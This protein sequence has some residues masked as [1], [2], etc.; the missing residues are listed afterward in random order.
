MNSDDDTPKGVGFPIRKSRDQRVLASSPGLSQRATSFI[1][2]RRQGIHQMP[3]SRSPR[4]S[5]NTKG[6]PQSLRHSA[7]RLRGGVTASRGPHRRGAQ[8]PSRREPLV[9][10]HAAFEHTH[11]NGRTPRP[12]LRFDGRPEIKPSSLIPPRLHK[13]RREMGP[14][15]HELVWGTNQQPPYDVQQEHMNR[16]WPAIPSDRAAFAPSYSYSFHTPP[17]SQHRGV[18]RRETG[19]RKAVERHHTRSQ[20]R[21]RLPGDDLGGPGLT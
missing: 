16:A 21:C 15:E 8:R 7:S 3:F 14:D 10:G 17:F 2:S 6:T 18:P 4:S 1:A 11:A 12:S 19:P 13:C 9:H 5:R 20:A